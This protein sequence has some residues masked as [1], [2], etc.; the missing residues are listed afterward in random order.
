[1]VGND[2]LGRLQYGDYPLLWYI[3]WHTNLAFLCFGY[4]SRNGR[5]AQAQAL[6][7]P[8]GFHE[9]MVSCWPSE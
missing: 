6:E 3:A 9:F 7:N 2:E 4:D 5:I 1:M 8:G